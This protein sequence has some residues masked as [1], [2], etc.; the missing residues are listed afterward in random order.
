MSQS[1]ESHHLVGHCHCV[2]SRRQFFHHHQ[3]VHQ[4]RPQERGIVHLFSMFSWPQR[5]LLHSSRQQLHCTVL[6]CS[7]LS[8]S[9]LDETQSET[10]QHG[11]P[12]EKTL[13]TKLSLGTLRSVGRER[14]IVGIVMSREQL[15]RRG[16]RRAFCRFKRQKKTS[17]RLA[18]QS[19]HVM[20][21]LH[22][23]NNT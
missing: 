13:S 12:V 21:S 19:Q 22:V 2:F 3:P 1:L 8:S 23:S 4:L 18:L 11:G 7:S 14:V 10:S 15:G 20:M 6:C 16:G 5:K 17:S 9:S